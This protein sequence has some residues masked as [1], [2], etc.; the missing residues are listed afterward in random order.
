MTG[1][2]VV[3]GIE[4]SC[5]ETGAG[6]GQDGRLR[7]QAVAS[8][9]D[10]HARFGGVVP[11]IAARAHVHAVAPVVREVPDRAGLTPGD[12]APDV[13]AALQEAIA[14]VLTR[15]AVR[16][17][18]DQGISTVAMVGG[19]AATPASG[20]WPRSA[21]PTRGS[22]CGCRRCGSARTT[23]RWSPPVDRPVGAAGV[24]GTDA[25][26]PGAGRRGAVATTR[27]PAGS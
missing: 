20:R 9:M 8:S 3:L 7:G 24:R 25:D 10:E 6:L 14:D 16:A 13:A 27:R 19:V 1:S 15:K 11:E 26:R 22:P 5:D 4:S 2:P 17:C 12:V 18:T 21:A 23:A